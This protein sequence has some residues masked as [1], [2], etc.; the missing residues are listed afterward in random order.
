MDRKYYLELCQHNS[1]QPKSKKVLHKGIEYY[2][3]KLVVWFNSKGE[4]QNTARMVSVVGNSVMEANIK[5]IEE[6]E[7]DSKVV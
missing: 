4:T 3:E 5:D 6:I 2:P 7:N 1:I